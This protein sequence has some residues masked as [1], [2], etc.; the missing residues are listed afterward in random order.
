MDSQTVGGVTFTM[1]TANR[2]TFVQARAMLHRDLG[3]KW[4][5]YALYHAGMDGECTVGGTTVETRGR[6][7]TIGDAR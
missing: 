6:F 1:D 4:G 7:Y 2:Y 3:R 5:A